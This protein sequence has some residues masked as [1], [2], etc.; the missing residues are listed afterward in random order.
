MKLFLKRTRGSITV[1]VTLIMV[2]TIFLIGFLTD[3]ARMKLYSNQALMTADNYGEAV[4]SDYDNLLKELYGLFAVTQNDK[5]KAAL[6]ELEEYMTTS[7]KPNQ[8]TISSQYFQKAQERWGLNTSYEGFMPY[9][10]AQVTVSFKR[11]P[12]ANLGNEEILTTQIG[13][14]MRFRIAQQLAGDGEAV[15]EA[16]ETVENTEGEAKVINAKTELDEQAGKVM[17][18]A[19]EYY[20]VLAVV[21]RYPSYI[22]AINH[23]YESTK[24][25]YKEIYD[26]SSYQI[27]KDYVT[28]ESEIAAARAKEQ[29]LEEGESLSNWEKELIE[30]GDR[31]DG[32]S[33][34]RRNKLKEKFDKTREEYVEAGI[35]E[36]VDFSNFVELVEELNDRA[37]KVKKEIGKLQTAKRELDKTMTENTIDT[38]LKE[39]IL[40]DLKNLEMLFGNAGDFSAENYVNL[41]AEIKT[42]NIDLY[43]INGE[44]ENMYT[45]T[46]QTLMD[47][48]DDYLDCAASVTKYEES[49]AEG[50]YYNFQGNGSYLALFE[51]L[52]ACFSG[53]EDTA[54]YEK[55]KNEANDKLKE[56]ER[57]LSRDEQTTV[58][59][60][61][62]EFGF[63]EG[64]TEG[65]FALTNMIKEAVSYF[66]MNSAS[67][68]GN[69]LLLK[70]YTVSYDFGMFSSRIT[71]VKE[72]EEEAVSLTGVRM[73]PEV[74]YLYGAEL[75]YLLGGDN[76]SK[77]NLNLA[78]N[79]IL[80]FRAVIN[81]RATYKVNAINTPIKGVKDAC[82]AIN[83]VLGIAVAGAL[84][85]AVAGVE[86]YGDWE[87][88]KKGNSV[89]L[90]K[91][92][93]RDLTTYGEI[94]N[95]LAAS[96][97]GSA[98]GSS[99]SG[100]SSSGHKKLRMDYEQYLMVM[101]IALTTSQQVERRTGNLITLNVNTVRGR[102]GPDRSAK[103]NSL[104][105]KL[106][107]AVTAVDAT[108][109][110]HLDFVVM[111]DGFAKQM[112]SDDTYNELSQFEKNTYQFTVTR[113]Y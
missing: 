65:N 80:A 52:D 40:G 101:M 25:E 49:L 82:S 22:A 103:L 54:K 75:E 37:D 104:D 36:P 62:E 47:I 109:S 91:N 3:L 90:I 71:N 41:A 99:T 84:R 79:R 68:A 51:S 46:C 17:E 83:P 14:F 55:Q 31:Y 92:D 102:V 5:G 13:D 38:D 96:S 111:P 73:G 77:E 16:I 19:K 69:R 56:K 48:R 112:T 34:A 98:G 30:M 76:S 59:D 26:S 12:G 11:V 64:E 94:K 15:L 85:A 18:K 58:R 9:Q 35:S 93:L 95:L 105:W 20:G 23:Q 4:I 81:M 33:E 28:H 100:N 53:E 6:K 67:E 27:Y 97:E 106:S 78:R 32:D 7:F 89:V 42:K 39:G 57:A 45:G 24:K 60:I 107:E 43:N 2:P 70:A 86:T 88:L 74:N 72:G 10:N 66:G 87:E 63:G 21:N 8:N 113:G 110:V 108:C 44:Y 29:N 61:P 50:K 1:M